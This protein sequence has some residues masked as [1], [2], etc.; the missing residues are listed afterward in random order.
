MK[1]TQ[2]WRVTEGEA[3]PW[4][5]C[6]SCAHWDTCSQRKNS[7]RSAWA[8]ILVSQHVLNG[9]AFSPRGSP[10][11]V[12]L[13][14]IDLSNPHQP[15]LITRPPEGLVLGGTFNDQKKKIIFRISWLNLSLEDSDFVGNVHST[16]VRNQL[17][18]CFFY[19]TRSGGCP[20]PHQCHGA[21]S[22][23]VG[24]GVRWPWAPQWAQVCW[25]LLPSSWMA[26]RSEAT[27]SWC[28]GQTCFSGW[29]QQAHPT[30]WIWRRRR[31]KS[32]LIKIF[33]IYLSWR[34]ITVL[35]SYDADQS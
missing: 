18:A 17:N 6:G 34:I 20:W 9:P 12:I 22:E 8:L 21:S 32:I 5:A 25:E 26:G 23:S 2:Q 14:P 24:P 4:R 15:P 30:A 29:P 31:R 27:G 11:T 10:A 19:Q 3:D 35:L 28:R 33:L 16:T 1:G 7:L 13:S